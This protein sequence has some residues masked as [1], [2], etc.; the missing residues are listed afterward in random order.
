MILNLQTFS[1]SDSESGEDEV[2]FRQVGKPS[3][4]AKKKQKKQESD[5]EGKF[6]SRILKNK[7]DSIWE[8]DFHLFTYI[9][10]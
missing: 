4:K 6:L 10:F 5:T 1:D 3:K 2:D 7:S 9:F 8:K